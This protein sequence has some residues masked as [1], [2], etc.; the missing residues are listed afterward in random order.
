MRAEALSPMAATTAERFDS[1]FRARGWEPFPEQLEAWEAQARGA[2][3]LL[4]I[5]TGS[6][7]TYAA[8]LGL[9]PL[10]AEHPGRG[11]R[12]VYVTPLRSL[13]RDIAR[14]IEEA[15]VTISDEIEVGLQTGDTDARTKARY[16]RRLPHVL[17]TTPESLTL[18]CARRDARELFASCT[19]VVVDEWHELLSTK[20]GTQTELA[21]ARIRN[22]SERVI[23]WG[24]S[25]TLDDPKK[26]AHALV[27]AKNPATV[28]HARVPRPVDVEI[29]CP[30]SVDA[31]PWAGHLGLHLLPKVL[32]WLDPDSSTLIFANTRSQVER[33]Y[34]ALED[35]TE[36]MMSR[37]ALHH[38]SLDRAERA[39]V[40]RGLREGSIRWVVCTSSLD[41]GVDFGPV[42]QVV[43][44]GSPRGASRLVQRAGRSKHR[45][46]EVSRILCV[47]THALEI[48]EIHATRRAV[49]E[50]RAEPRVPMVAPADVL[51]QHMVT[52]A[53]GGG[54]DADALYREVKT[55]AAYES[56]PRESFDEVLRF[57]RDGGTALK[58]YPNYRKIELQDGAY[59]VSDRRIARMHRV[60]IG[61]I[62]SDAAIR[63]R[64][65]G[66]KRLGSVEESFFSRI[67]PGDR[68]AYAGRVL[69]LVRLRDSE[70]IV[71]RARGTSNI[72]PRWTGGRMA[73]SETVSALL[74]DTLRDLD[75]RRLD[76]E[77]DPSL[78]VLAPLIERQRE[79]S[80]LPGAAPLIERWR[81]KQG[82]H[83]FL[84][85]F[86]GYLAHEGLG[87]LLSY[88]LSKHFPAT[89]TT[90]S[91]DY[92]F[93]L[94][95]TENVPMH[96][97]ER[98]D[99]FSTH[100]LEADIL[101]A[102]NGAELGKQQF[103]EVARVSG[104]VFQGYPG[105]S[106][107]V[108]QLQ[109]SASLIYDVLRKYEPSSPMLA[110][111]HRE[112]LDQKLDVERVH[113]ALAFYASE[114]AEVDIDY[115]TP[116]AFP[117]VVRRVGARLS[118][119]S[120]SARIERMKA[121]WLRAK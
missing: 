110:Q 53:V 39:R 85:P 83:F 79:R 24:L 11:L 3:G 59:V 55:T 31:F 46:G 44:I 115:P 56:L 29:L 52:C 65:I 108:G 76:Y 92:G 49:D 98:S 51:A 64:F 95:S 113:R 63:V 27:G 93:E 99:L 114:R 87:A 101:E 86:A 21:L 105:S 107:T 121:A 25:A 84:Y 70:A 111:A 74:L 41:L 14:A 91:N 8:T 42:D 34:R 106:K 112:V 120:L 18:L 68:F 20:R 90:S 47:P 119:E 40:E 16:R 15:A 30:E 89:F 37:I 58:A 35:A 2:S 13:A 23:T 50:S 48:L 81:S 72:T 103:R 33:W 7:K 45:R 1:F 43:Q 60:S 78:A 17:V 10:L 102:V 6:G 19:A 80:R 117:L 57:V 104:L 66:G 118:S 22:F 4:C 54:F 67:R 96:A 26:A 71:K 116:F 69:E 97:F 73:M 9:L 77:S 88:R 62:T 94:F 32:E 5:P 100:R 36:G 109:M 61:T 38:G 82:T 28:I 75:E 12:L